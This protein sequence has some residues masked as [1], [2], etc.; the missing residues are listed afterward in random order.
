MNIRDKFITGNFIIGSDGQKE[1]P[2]WKDYALKLEEELI[3]QHRAFKIVENVSDKNDEEY[4]ELLK[5]FDKLREEL[6]ETINLLKT[7]TKIYNDKFLGGSNITFFAFNGMVKTC[8]DKI[9][10]KV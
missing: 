2:S 6:N 1:P 4:E 8:L 5:R 10:T 3:K 7:F 9:T